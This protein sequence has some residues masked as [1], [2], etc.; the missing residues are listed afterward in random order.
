MKINSYSVKIQSVWL[1]VTYILLFTDRIAAD[2]DTNLKPAS[3]T[4][5]NSANTKLANKLSSM[6]SKQFVDDQIRANK[7]SQEFTTFRSEVKKEVNHLTNDFQVEKHEKT[8]NINTDTINTLHVVD[9]ATGFNHKRIKTQK[10]R[11]NRM[12]NCCNNKK[13]SKDN[14]PI[15][16]IRLKTLPPI[17]KFKIKHVED[18]GIIA[19]EIKDKKY[20][21]IIDQLQ[22]E[23]GCLKI[24]DEL[25]DEDSQIPGC[26]K[27]YVNDSNAN[28]RYECPMENLENY[29]DIEDEESTNLMSEAEP[30]SDKKPIKQKKTVKVSYEKKL[31]KENELLSKRQE[32]GK[33]LPKLRAPFK[34]FTSFR[35]EDSKF[36]ESQRKI[37]EFMDG[38]YKLGFSLN[39]DLHLLK[40]HYV[41]SAYRIHNYNPNTKYQLDIKIIDI[42]DC[43]L[44]KTVQV[45]RNMLYLGDTKYYDGIY[46]QKCYFKEFKNGPLKVYYQKLRSNI[47]F[48]DYIKNEHNT[49]VLTE[50]KSQCKQVY[51]FSKT[52][53]FKYLIIKQIIEITKD[54]IRKNLIIQDFTINNISLLDNYNVRFRNFESL[55]RFHAR[56][57][58]RH[59]MELAELFG[60]TPGRLYD[61][62]IVYDHE[63]EIAG[64]GSAAKELKK[65]FVTNVEEVLKLIFKAGPFELEDGYSK[66]YNEC[67]EK[68]MANRYS[69]G[70]DDTPE[71]LLDRLNQEYYFMYYMIR[72]KRSRIGEKISKEP[73][74]TLSCSINK[75][76]KKEMDNEKVSLRR[77]TWFGISKDSDDITDKILGIYNKCY[78]H[79]LKFMK[80]SF[81]DKYY[82]TYGPRS[83]GYWA[84]W[85]DYP[86][87]LTDRDFHMYFLRMEGPKQ[88]YLLHLLG[89]NGNIDSVMIQNQK[90]SKVRL[91]YLKDN[92]T[93]SSDNRLYV[94]DDELVK[95]EKVRQVDNNI[96]NNLCI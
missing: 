33:K 85:Y 91:L 10:I 11:S 92:N 90:L 55:E 48:I 62:M 47:E 4:V 68:N 27:K 38:T 6:I 70:S 95:N 43:L 41:E 40:S 76:L 72:K 61:P 56:V 58:N 83:I 73:E 14:S 88:D 23:L 15:K 42:K 5:N 69:P 25:E 49:S 46:E 36:S 7:T 94:A 65:E 96:S 20:S 66:L 89:Y 77:S 17:P 82:T 57:I 29:D 50:T 87:Y 8:E 34:F 28:G 81:D 51:D 39:D 9:K 67:V 1:M 31:E 37:D 71:G 59:N 13:R 63:I 80:G 53:E 93:G 30:E 45:L 44:D 64:D 32:C 18:P 16:L 3:V 52:I 35:Y 84:S 2:V 12:L 24:N 54:L 75:T 26:V 78:D 60:F 86:H 19:E 21:E 22:Y 79:K 74:I